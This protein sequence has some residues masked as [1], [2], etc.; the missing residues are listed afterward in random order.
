MHSQVLQYSK[1][2]GTC[3]AD[4]LEK[5]WA[6]ETNRARDIYADFNQ[7]TLDITLAALFGTELASSDLVRSPLIQL[8]SSTHTV[9]PFYTGHQLHSRNRPV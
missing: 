7:L 2:M 5:L 6:P 8:Y 1:A 9:E 4:M 3:T